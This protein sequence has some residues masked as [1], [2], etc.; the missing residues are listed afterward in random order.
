MAT[1]STRTTLANGATIITTVTDTKFDN[2]VIDVSIIP[3]I[4]KADVKFLAHRLRPNREVF[5]YFDDVAVQ[6][7]V[8]KPD[9]IRL[10]DSDEYNDLRSDQVE[11]TI[12]SGTGNS[13][14]ILLS[15]RDPDTN[16]TVLSVTNV[17]GLFANSATITGP[18]NTSVILEYKHFHGTASGGAAGYITLA[19]AAKHTPNNYWGTDSSNTIY[20]TDGVG[21]GQ[22]ATITGYNNVSRQLSISGAFSPVPTS[23]TRYS[24]GPWFTDDYGSLPGVFLIPNYPSLQFK[25]GDRIFRIIDVATN[26]VE[27]CTTRVDYVFTSSGLIQQKNEVVLKDISTTIIPPPTPVVIPPVT[28]PVPPVV[29]NPPPRRTVVPAQPV[30]GRQ[31]CCF[32][33]DTLVLMEDGSHKRIADIEIDDIVIGCTGHNKVIGIEIPKLGDRELYTLNGNH[34]AW[35]TAEHP[36]YVLDKGW[37]SIDPDQTFEDHKFKVGSLTIGDIVEKYTGSEEITSITVFNNDP[38]LPVYNLLL[39]GDH[40]YFANDYLVHNKA[41]E[42]PLS[43][44]FFVDGSFF[45]NGVFVTSIDLFFKHKDAN[46]LPVMVQIRPTVNGYPHSYSVV[47]NATAVVE[48]QKVNTSNL[49]N[50]AD[51]ATAT[52][53]KFPSPVY[54]PPGEWAMVIV[55]NSVEYELYLAELGETQIG[56]SRVISEQPYI[57]SLFKS[58]NMSTWTPFQL[59]DVMF[60]I[61]RADFDFTG[62]VLFKNRVPDENVPTDRLFTHAHDYL[63][64]NTGIRYTHSVDTGATFTNYDEDSHYVPDNRLNIDVEGEYQL[65]GVLSTEDSA[66][67]PIVYYK[68]YTTIGIQNIINNANITNTQVVVTSGGAGYSANANVALLF[69]TGAGNTAPAI[70]FAIADGT[71]VITQVLITD[72]GQYFVNDMTVSPASGNATFNFV[73]EADP[74]GG[75]AL[76]KYV[77]R[78]V[79]LAEGFDAGDLR[80]FITANKVAGTDIKL[81][82]KIRNTQDPE[83]F[84]QKNWV[85]M[86]QKTSAASISADER[87]KIEYEYRPSLTENQLSYTTTDGVTYKTFQQ[88]AIKIV[89]LSDNT[90]KYPV[91]YDLRGIALPGIS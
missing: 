28:P 14:L 63:P 10:R 60:K 22:S 52:T 73:S 71:G 24:I 33:A 56:T 48:A 9:I 19:L 90:V 66:V 41:G 86:P 32:V 25:T 11:D 80:V 77:S 34:P 40:T 42:D 23:N 49:P 55:S 72:G 58:Q 70:G 18:S 47:P 46:N 39:D 85:L 36:F 57:G 61:R 89:L 2:G 82:F 7:Y 45:P 26:D 38:E 44:T 79:N 43:Q 29:V 1:S 8:Q 76:A 59:E 12:T 30:S 53:F 6:K 68:K 69:G 20:L 74:A 78:I 3:F 54:L 65:Q 91:V 15:Q 5:F 50:V 4:K 67:S 13:A 87:Q 84:D 21:I 31:P 62:T 88:F 81:Y 35:F 75:P 51:P 37:A 64:P 27:D 83:S 17:S 16:L